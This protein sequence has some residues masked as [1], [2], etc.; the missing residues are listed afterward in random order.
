[1]AI[2]EVTNIKKIYTTRFGANKV[3]ALSNVNFTVE[4]GEY[5]AIM[6]ESGS[7]KTTLLNIAG[8]MLKA[9][10]G[11]VERDGRTALVL[12]EPTIFPELSVKDNLRMWYAAQNLPW[13]TPGA[14]SIEARLGLLPYLGKKAGVLSGGMKKR[15]SIACALA[16]SP[17]CLLLDEPFAALDAESCKLLSEL[18]NSLKSGGASILFTSHEPDCIA[19]TADELWILENGVLKKAAEL[20]SASSEERLETVLRSIWGLNNQ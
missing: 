12:Q 7:G 20:S 8:K 9:D 14:D 6:G 16:G 3:Q 17:R 2:L 10:S 5:I 1:M 11:T 4:R 18:L 19:D 13:R 15:L